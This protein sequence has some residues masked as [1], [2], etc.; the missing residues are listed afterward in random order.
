MKKQ[1]TFVREKFNPYGGAER[2]FQRLIDTLQNRNLYRVEI[3]EFPQP[4]WMSSWLKI[5]LFNLKACRAKK[6]RF[7]FSNDR[8]ICLDIHRAGGGT[9]KAFL[10]T[11][12]FTLNPFHPVALWIEKKTLE[13]T[14]K[15]IANSQKVKRDILESYD[16]PDSKIEVI[17]NGV[18]I[19]PEFN[20]IDAKKKLQ[21][22]F[23]ID[24]KDKIILY[25]GSG[26]ERKGVW[27]LLEILSRVKGPYRAFIVGKDKR[28]NK[29]KK[30]TKKLGME[31]KIF[32]TGPRRDVDLFYKSADIFLF[33][34]KY[35]PFSNVVLEALSYGAVVFTTK[36]NGASEILDDF[37]VMESPKDINISKKL[38]R[39]LSNNILLKE[40][41]KKAREIPKEYTIE[42]NVDL[43]VKLIQEV[44][45]NK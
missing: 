39:L 41:Q 18:P 11:K 14:K 26:F 33:P 44:L 42:K 6:D 13:N 9:H 25:V 23:K 29:Y 35:E 16:I 4:K 19:P 24:M 15:I 30:Y 21:E 43:T 32:F 37:Y 28:M 20:K 3:L 40:E 22:E 34:T 17:Y 7:Y 1:I 38:D 5:I 31:N 36:Q 10:K 27:E 2:Y 12:G 45:E 8:L